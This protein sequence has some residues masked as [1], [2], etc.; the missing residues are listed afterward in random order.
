MGDI[1]CSIFK[2]CCKPKKKVYMKNTSLNRNGSNQSS[3]LRYGKLVGRNRKISARTRNKCFFDQTIEEEE[4]PEPPAPITLTITASEPAGD[5]AIIDNGI[6]AQQTLTFSFTISEQ[7]NNFTAQDIKLVNATV[8]NFQKVDDD[9]DD[10]APVNETYTADITATN[11]GLVK[12][13][14]DSAS[15]TNIGGYCNNS[16]FFSYTYDSTGPIFTLSSNNINQ[17]GL[18]NG[19]VITLS[20][21][22][23]ELATEPDVLNKFTIIKPDDSTATF[24]TVAVNAA[25]QTIGNH[26][27]NW[28]V[29][30]S[31]IDA[32]GD[33]EI[34][35]DA[36]ASKDIVGNDSLV[37]DTTSDNKL[38]F[39]RDTEQPE[40]TTIVAEGVNDGGITNKNQIK[41]TFTLNKINTTFDINSL[42]SQNTENAIGNL[43]TFTP[44][45]DSNFSVL[46]DTTVND[47]YIVKVVK[48][49]I[50]DQAGNKNPGTLFFTFTVDKVQPT[51]DIE[52]YSDNTLTTLIDTN[53]TKFT[54]QNNL[55]L[56]FTSSKQTTTFIR[57]IIN[58]NNCSIENFAQK[59]G[60][61]TY[62][63][64]LKM[65]QDGL[66]Q[67][68]VNE[69]MFSDTVGNLNKKSNIIEITRDTQNPT[70]TLRT[71][72]IINGFTNKDTITINIQSDL[73]VTLGGGQYVDIRETGKAPDPEVRI[74]FI[75]IDNKNFRAIIS[76]LLMNK[77][78]TF[79]QLNSQYR[80]ASGNLN[81]PPLP[82][83]VFDTDNVIPELTISAT[84]IDELGEAARNVNDSDIVYNDSINIKIVSTKKLFG[85]F[86]SIIEITN[87]KIVDGTFQV[88]AGTNEL[89]YSAEVIANSD[90]KVIIEIPENKVR[91]YANNYNNMGVIFSWF[92]D[93]TPPIVKLD[94][95]QDDWEYK[96]DTP[97]DMSL[98]PGL[99]GTI[100]N[101]ATGIA[102]NT[103]KYIEIMVG[104]ID[105][106]GKPAYNGTLSSGIYYIANDSDSPT[107]AWK[108]NLKTIH[109]LDNV[110]T[111]TATPVLNQTELNGNFKRMAPKPLTIGS[112]GQFDDS[113][114]IEWLDRLNY[115]TNP[116]TISVFDDNDNFS[117]GTN[118]I[119]FRFRVYDKNDNISEPVFHEINMG[120]LLEINISSD[121]VV[122][123]KTGKTTIQL[124][125]TGNVDFDFDL[126]GSNLT[127]NAL[128][129]I[130]ATTGD[131]GE[132]LQ[133]SNKK[134]INNKTYTVEAEA[135]ANGNYSI[136]MDYITPNFLNIY[137]ITLENAATN[138]ALNSEVTQKINPTSETSTGILR[139]IATNDYYIEHTG[140][141]QFQVEINGTDDYNLKDENGDDIE[142]VKDS[143]YT[144]KTNSGTLGLTNEIFN[145]T[146]EQKDI[147]VVITATTPNGVAINT[148]SVTND[149]SINVTFTV[150]NF[151]TSHN[152]DQTH[153]KVTNGIITNFVDNNDDTFS[154]VLNSTTDGQ[155]IITVN[156][157]TFQ[158][159][160]F[161]NNSPLSQFT[162]TRDT[163]PP[164]INLAAPNIIL[165]TIN[166]DFVAPNAT[167]T[168]IVD[169]VA[170]NPAP[171]VNVDVSSL[172]TT[173]V[174]DYSIT[175]E[176]TDNAGK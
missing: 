37:I 124:T 148:E 169:G 164:V 46:L 170:Q 133:L 113:S 35:I 72:D 157:N 58:T 83:I 106:K 16:G 121:D 20:I 135:T 163:K 136:K 11:D 61:N 32:D 126:P 90:G 10:D 111:L 159:K 134:P 176:S 67:V 15:F 3:R 68:F 155:C 59:A 64:E 52:L 101:S 38:Q 77:N 54:N 41:L 45:D 76:N 30:I 147:T 89:E 120:N 103:W 114:Y 104:N 130:D 173:V 70:I 51:I 162:W 102:D 142:I 31:N 65:T 175:Y 153:I 138:P 168:D 56:K 13:T 44:I 116:P 55:F 145:Y 97:E 96:L 160:I 71:D 39:T 140:G 74:N 5:G 29:D 110:A 85:F 152:F 171:V 23:N 95:N 82:S 34:L 115:T 24:G 123:D 21:T 144:A 86:Q 17:H 150:T 62:E 7:T 166:T 100:I 8:A 139:E 132:T 125:I 91:T 117:F 50:E 156:A 88:I 161:N 149:L 141:P 40:V 78:Y 84:A 128:S 174:G 94:N 14:I 158:D 25:T 172:D 119:K 127:N 112:G 53:I 98:G 47:T 49:S 108:F 79:L 42:L 146:R 2:N 167:A 12:V 99:T 33:Y 60:T 18:I 129:I 1:H 151:V 19:N 107:S 6:T 93:T 57:N 81:A 36:G 28:T 26:A 131:A 80:T 9:D 73:D 122:D 143:V 165:H 4:E 154:A 75:I 137:K 27:T 66:C 109:A 43:H 87:G 69:N 63:A 92:S 105:N 22:T 118:T 48:D